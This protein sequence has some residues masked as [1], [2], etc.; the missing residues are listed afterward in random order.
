MRVEKQL[1]QG[2]YRA[3]DFMAGYQKLVREVV[4]PYQYEVLSDKVEGVEKSH[5]LAN[6]INAGKVI[7]GDA[8]QS[9]GFYGMVFQDSD[10]A[11]WIEAVAYSL[12]NCPDR[13][14]EERADE[15]IE[16]IAGAQEP[17]GYLNTYYTCKDKEKRWTNL[18]EGHELYCSGHMMEAAVAYYEATGKR[19]LLEVMEK[20]LEHI[21]DRFIL[22]QA[23]GC[24]GHP[25]VEL[26]LLRM[27]QTTRS[28]HALELAKHF[29]NV[30]GTQ[31]DFFEKEAEKR[32]WQV[33]G[34]DPKDAEYVQAH[35][36]V[37]KQS[38][39]VGHAVRAV[40]LY[41]AMADLAAE[42]GD[43][44]LIAACKRLWRN[45]VDQKMYIT[46][47]IG[48]TFMG[49]AFTVNYN[50]P[51]DTI[52]AE[53]CASVGLMFFAAK[54]LEMEADSEYA[55]VMERAFYNTVLGGMQLDG[56]RFF[57]VNPLEVVPGISGKAVTHKH[58]LPER[59]GWYACACCPPNVA[60]LISSI[61]KYAYAESADT[62]YCHLFAAGDV[63]FDNGLALC[64]KTEYPYGFTISYQIKAGEGR[65]AIRIPDYSREK[66]SIFKNQTDITKEATGQIEKGYVY[67]TVKAADEITLHL[68]DTPYLV[69]PSAKI[70]NLSGM[71]ALCRGPLVYCFEG[72]D[73]EEDI[74]SLY[75]DGASEIR[76]K[77]KEA[78]SFFGGCRLQIGGYRKKVIEGLYTKAAPILQ[79]CHVEAI[80]YYA[81]GNRGIGEMRVWLPILNAGSMEKTL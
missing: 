59:P 38:E 2:N 1:K 33:W 4:I 70:P 55:D 6:F 27:Y 3:A 45:I 29:I 48:S 32:D 60:R 57:Y 79:S 25:E 56:K 20:N 75:L 42:I 10:A 11:K 18:L 81:W 72:R 41:T 12:V 39:A 61:G 46:G 19:K 24:P 14:L 30:R 71:A 47:G 22:N 31:P 73:N 8:E 7:A 62:A 51:N 68:T 58:V 26:A 67:L 69:Y 44:E 17:D 54:M 77:E 65:L 9:D 49:E 15:L 34:A 64:C 40:Y 16:I 50:L 53:T 66:Y 78:D 37:R 36:P 28:P 63:S 35:I 21:Y 76:T 43:A 74:L 52:Y 5:V 23:E 80:P 13:A